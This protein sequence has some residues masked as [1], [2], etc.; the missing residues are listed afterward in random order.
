[1]FKKHSAALWL[2]LAL[3]VLSALPASANK[4]DS[5]TASANCQ[6]YT[7]TAVAGDLQPGKTYVIEYNFTVICNGGSPINVPGSITFQ[8][9]G[10]TQTVTA[11]GAFPGVQGAGAC[12]V[13][14]VAAL[15]VGKDKQINIIINGVTKAPLS[16]SPITA[17]CALIVA[18]QGVP[19]TPVTLTASGGAGPPYT[20]SA[21]GLPNGITISPSGTISGTPTV[22]GTFS[23]TV[24]ITDS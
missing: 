20:F 4:L 16:C 7:L 12:V 5:A 10:K 14:G 2:V 23:Y 15:E 21:T 1:M 22:S 8:A 9:T 13:S 24:T 17:N 18:E 3:M 11:S 6:G 19:I